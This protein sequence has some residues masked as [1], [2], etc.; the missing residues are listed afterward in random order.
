MKVY[1]NSTSKNFIVSVAIGSTAKKNWEKFIKNNWINYCKK[2]NLG[3][4]MFFDNLID[5]SD[6]Y[7]KKPNWQKLLVGEKILKSKLK[8]SNIC[9]LDIDIL[10][11][12]L[13]SPNI[14]D[15]H[16]TKFISVVSQRKNLNFD[17]EYGLKQIAFNRNFF[18]SR[19]YPLDSAL[20]MNTKEIFK[21]H[22]FKI[23][24]KIID[25]DDYFCTGVFIFNIKIYSDFFKKIFY[26]YRSNSKTLTGGEEPILN[27]E[28]QKFG[29]INLLDYKF[30]SLWLYEIATKYPF[31]YDKK[32]VNENLILRCIE[33]SLLSNY[34]LHFAGSWGETEM[35]KINNINNRIFKSTRVRKLCEYLKRKVSSKPVGKILPKNK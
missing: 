5:K 2:N 29:K 26:K 1:L 20:F 16:K 10:I 14:F 35:W 27:Y 17:L 31:L 12:Y 30:Q 25:K 24:K 34:F 11:N 15:Y 21:Y 4:I 9:F 7:W 32:I 22:N 23:N 28:I 19:K 8:I 33:N 3:L 6:I 13:T 18:Y